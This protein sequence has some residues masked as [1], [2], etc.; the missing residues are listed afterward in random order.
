M[1]APQST[2]HDSFSSS[3][4]LD[5]LLV[6]QGFFNSR[7][8]AQAAIK[9]GYVQIDGHV[10]DKVAAKV[11]PD[12]EPTI[13]RHS[14]NFVS[15]GGLKLSHGLEAFGFPV[16]GR[17]VVDL[18]AS[19]G[20]FTDVVLKKGAAHCLA[21]DV[22]HGQLHTDLANDARVTSLEK[23]NAR[24]LSQEHLPQ[25]FQVTAIVCDVSFISLELALPPMLE[26]AQPDSWLI[27]LI[28]PQFEAGRAALGKGGVVRDENVHQQVCDKIAHWLETQSGWSVN[29]ITDSPV[30]GPKGNKEFLIGAVKS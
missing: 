23:V 8:Q 15:R 11:K 21:V 14:H 28:K 10:I 25:G 5:T 26:I 3:M 27:A 17:M 9:D 16:S 4:R 20:G 22:G 19:T 7:S 6:E 18:G 12:V 13:I 2:G 1:P 30:E 24:H 29:C